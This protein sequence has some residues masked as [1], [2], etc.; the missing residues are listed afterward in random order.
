[1][2][3]VDNA[4]YYAKGTYDESQKTGVFIV[5]VN[6]DGPCD[7]A[8]IKSG[9]ILTKIDDVEIDNADEFSSTIKRGEKDTYKII[10][11]INNKSWV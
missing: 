2:T 3:D 1:M 8:G 11:E 4:G 9:D 6:K 10:N 5:G 7:K